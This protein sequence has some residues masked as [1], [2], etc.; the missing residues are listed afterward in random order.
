MATGATDAVV[1]LWDLRKLRNFKS[2]PLEEHYELKSISFDVSG[3]YMAISGSDVRYHTMLHPAATSSNSDF[4]AHL[5]PNRGIAMKG[6]DQD[7]P[8]SNSTGLMG[9]ILK[10]EF[11]YIYFLT[12]L[13]SSKTC[14]VFVCF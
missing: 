10:G 2:I 3:A 14:V 9:I 8:P 12:H 6:R 1:K 13:T 5:K 11:K 7:N 4:H